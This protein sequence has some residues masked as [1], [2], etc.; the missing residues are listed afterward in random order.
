MIHID[1]QP[2]KTALG[3]AAAAA[4]AKAISAAIGE[5]G[6]ANIVVATGM[7]QFELL[8]ALVAQPGIDWSR[9]TAFHLDEYIGMPETHPASFRRYLTERFTSRL[10]DLRA[11]HFV[12][13]DAADVDAE[14]ERLD[15]LIAA[16]P[17]D[18]KIGRAHV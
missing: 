4:G 5:R 17:I 8:A 9:V 14:I 12:R 2:S 13:G 16:H 11:F 3:A 1:L 10:P 6:S 15:A 7:S 18:V